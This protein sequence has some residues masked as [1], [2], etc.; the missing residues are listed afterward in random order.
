MNPQAKAH[1]DNMKKLDRQKLITYLCF[2]LSGDHNKSM[3]QDIV[4]ALTVSKQPK[5]KCGINRIM[6]L[7]Q[8]TQKAE[9]PKPTGQ[10]I[11]CTIQ[12]ADPQKSQAP[13]NLFSDNPEMIPAKG[14]AGQMDLF[15]Q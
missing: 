10:I 15:N 4:E 5:S 13:G 8:E 7:V 14:P 12:K 2:S 11:M 9:T 6:E 3:R 1:I